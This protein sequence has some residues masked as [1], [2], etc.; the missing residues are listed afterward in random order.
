MELSFHVEQLSAL[1]MPGT[2]E[3]RL[4]VWPNAAMLGSDVRTSSQA[5][6]QLACRW[7]LWLR[8]L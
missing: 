1:A 3:P 5:E 7:D 4:K 8:A 2:L 6:K